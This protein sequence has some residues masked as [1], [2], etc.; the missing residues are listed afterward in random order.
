MKY[1]SSGRTEIYCPHRQLGP[2]EIS[3]GER[4]GYY[5]VNAMSVLIVIIKL[6][7]CQTLWLNSE[8][9]FQRIKGYNENQKQFFCMQFASEISVLYNFLLS[10]PFFKRA[11]KKRKKSNLIT[12]DAGVVFAEFVHS[13]GGCCPIL[14]RLLVWLRLWRI[15]HS[16]KLY[17][18]SC[19]WTQIRRRSVARP[20][21]GL[22]PAYSIL[23]ISSW[24]CPWPPSPPSTTS[25][26]STAFVNES[27]SDGRRLSVN[28]SS[29]LSVNLSSLTCVTTAS[30]FQALP[31]NKHCT[32]PNG[33]VDAVCLNPSTFARRR[34][35]EN[36]VPITPLSPL[37][38]ISVSPYYL[39]TLWKLVINGVSLTPVTKLFT[40]F[41]VETMHAMFATSLK[42]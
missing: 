39:K 35:H 23:P 19:F 40:Y 37:P 25:T 36:S 5:D 3:R 13:L 34:P 30:F 31:T 18:Q 1:L 16:L 10:F 27:S 41:I 2:D 24:A 42:Q 12:A 4:C 28:R 20:C 6:A 7:L 11:N 15:A 38:I 26:S 21:S 14:L 33:F 22:S 29:L 17:L 8:S 9:K 32:L